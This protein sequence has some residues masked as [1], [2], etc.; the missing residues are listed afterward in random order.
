MENPN[1]AMLSRSFRIHQDTL[2]VLEEEA[3]KKDLGITVYIRR[4]LESF[5][6]NL[7]AEKIQAAVEAFE[8][9]IMNQIVDA[10]CLQYERQY[11]EV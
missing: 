5:V 4:I 3:L 6:E 7:Q 11:E 9:E 8:D 10:E 1:G 2:A